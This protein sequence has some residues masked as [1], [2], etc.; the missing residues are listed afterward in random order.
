MRTTVLAV[1]ALAAFAPALRAQN[2]VVPP[3][4]GAT[5]TLDEAIITARQNN[6]IYLSQTNARRTA[7]ANIRATRGALLPSADAYFG[8]RYQEAGQQFV[9]GAPLS[10]SGNSLQGNYGASLNYSVN[11]GAFAAAKAATATRDAVDADIIGQSEQLRAAVTQQYLT[12]LQAQAR[13]ALQDT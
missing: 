9:N 4:P 8:S 6:P 3:M 11:A 1:L 13:S 7:D 10:A 12:V 2:G 5:L